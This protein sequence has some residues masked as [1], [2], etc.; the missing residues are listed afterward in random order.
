MPKLHAIALAIPLFGLA[1]ACGSA[2]P[3]PAGDDGTAPDAMLPPPSPDGRP[4]AMPSP[5]C[6]VG[7][8]DVMTAHVVISTDDA[9]RLWVNGVL[10]DD[11][12]R[13]WD[14]PGV[15][16]V[17]I[18][19]HPSR[20][21]VI[22]IEGRNE[23]N[24]DGRDRGLI[25]DMRFT[26]NGAE[27]RIVTDSSWKLGINAQPGWE[28]QTFSDASWSGPVVIGPEGID[29]WYDVL[30]ADAPASTAS[31]L[32]WYDPTPLAASEKQ[33]LDYAYARKSF[34]VVDPNCQ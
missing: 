20:R 24:I 32:W 14:T 34:S 17:A 25:A 33:D 21:N 15:Y 7:I 13:S 27:Q 2:M 29:P 11:Q 5:T 3:D 4:D 1:A 6:N 30:G 31:W 12:P 18:L 16:D 19:R 22:A 8:D 28:T 26:V 23:L 10:I 9:Y